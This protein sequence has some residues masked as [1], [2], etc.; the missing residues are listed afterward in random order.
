MWHGLFHRWSQKFTGTMCPNRA[1]RINVWCLPGHLISSAER[2][3]AQVPTSE[4]C[5]FG[6]AASHRSTH[7]QQFSIYICRHLSFETNISLRLCNKMTAFFDRGRGQK[8]EFCQNFR[9]IS[10]KTYGKLLRNIGN[11]TFAR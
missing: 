3:V 10:N 1:E 4:S 2:S 6:R 11:I 8:L 5:L 7:V 9:H